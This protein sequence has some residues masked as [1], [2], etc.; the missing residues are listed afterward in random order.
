VDWLRT[1]AAAR[2]GRAVPEN[3]S[4]IERILLGKGSQSETDKGERVRILPLASIGH[5]QVD[6]SVRR[7][8]V[9]VPGE[10]PLSPPDV[11]WAFSGLDLVNPETGE[12]LGPQLVPADEDDRMLSHY[13]SE[14]GHR[15]WRSV[16]PLALPEGA[17][18]RRIEPTRQ[19]EEGKSGKERVSEE[20]RAGAAVLQALRHAGY[21]TP[22]ELIQVQREPFMRKGER[23]ERFAEGS[24]FRKERLWHVRLQFR[25]PVVGPLVLGDGRFLG[26]G[27]MAP[28]PDARPVIAYEIVS[29]LTGEVEP[30]RVV[31]ALRRAVM[32]RVQS[33]LGEIPP[34]FSGHLPDGQPVRDDHGHL[35]FAAQ[36]PARLFIFAP[37]ASANRFA[38]LSKAL[39]GFDDLRAGECGRLRLRPL[40]VADQD[41]IVGSF[42]RW[43]SVTQYEPTRHPKKHDL[44]E[45][46]LRKDLL[47][48][49]ARRHLPVPV[50]VEVLS[51]EIGPRRGG[52]RAR[53]RLVFGVTVP[54]PICL[55]KSS[56]KGGG[57]FAGAR[58]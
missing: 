43:E 2:L 40:Y 11:F 27:V 39:E 30:R 45:D 56:H 57:L 21:S 38:Q 41:P 24:R 46:F 20:N 16:T 17:A 31:L 36:L 22:V 50:D 8:L 4:T 55:G 52:I 19:R 33:L 28:E 18:R 29:G 23:A 35:A 54:G 32:A 49:L 15:V 13:G 25:Q 51:H 48:E 9:E 5:K 44:T 14:V 12:V 47:G 3:L 10:C 53:I 1:G 7:V 34:Y 58:D 37:R 26:L 42:R 6:M